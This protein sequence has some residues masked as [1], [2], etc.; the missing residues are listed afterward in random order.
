MLVSQV[1][2]IIEHITH[3]GIL[4]SRSP[5]VSIILPAYN[6]DAF[7]Q[8]S[9]DSLLNQSFSDFECLIIEGASTDKTPDMIQQAV[10]NDPRVFHINTT[11]NISLPS[12]LN[13]G[14]AAAKGDYIARMDADDISEPTRLE[15]QLQFITE[16]KLDLIGS[17]GT[18]IDNKG[19]PIERLSL[20]QEDSAIKVGLSSN[21]QFIH[22][23]LFFKSTLKHIP[24]PECPNEDYLWIC[25]LMSLN[26]K[27][28]NIPEYL[29]QYRRHDS[30][31]SQYGKYR[32]Y[33]HAMSRYYTKHYR[34]PHSAFFINQS[35]QIR[36]QEKQATCLSAL[37]HGF[38]YYD[39]WLC[40]RV[41]F[42]YATLK[43]VYRALLF[44]KYYLLNIRR[45]HALEQE[46]SDL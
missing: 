9:L 31:R 21:S 17:Y 26:I 7:F 6:S 38:I 11:K 45:I 43:I 18:V 19:T 37:Q 27:F 4:L 3:R 12:A 28:G 14:L 22:P 30:N 44:S 23:S 13:A 39:I 36:F 1:S 15:K 25:K 2:R 10:D 16:K 24:Y 42:K 41:F 29:I 8:S 46:L 34:Q 20:P 40:I 35:K 32:H 33:S 5:K